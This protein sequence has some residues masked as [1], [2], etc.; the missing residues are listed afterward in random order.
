MKNF[1]NISIWVVLLAG[2]VI[3]LGFIESEYKNTTCKDMQIEITQSQDGILIDT[4]DIA[5]LVANNYDT[6]LGK[7]L[8]DIDQR[9]IEGIIARD[10]YIENVHV[11]STI[12][13]ILKIHAIQR[14]AIIR[15]FNNKY[16]SF[17]IDKSGFVVPVNSKYPVRLPIAT[18]CIFNSF[19]N[20][21][22]QTPNVNTITDTLYKFP[23]LHQIYILA[24]FIHHDPF[25]SS[26]INQINVTN[27]DEFELIPRI[28]KQ[29][30]IFGDLSDM[31][32]K[33]TKLIAFYKKGMAVS[34]WYKYS[35]INLKYK[36][37]VI[38]TKT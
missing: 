20:L 15:I 4:S 6:I 23:V 36:N 25:L 37:Q 30:I 5:G 2:T 14:Q 8:E 35:K 32:S 34:G 11:Y 1:I 17:Y 3:M 26:M 24:N 29:V 38:C 9:G 7:P 10:P 31:E 28:G 22:K 19:R 33:F 18:G 16:Q 21:D 27:K 12:D 13:G